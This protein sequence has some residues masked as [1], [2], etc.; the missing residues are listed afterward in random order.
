MTG[1]MHGKAVRC[2]LCD[3]GAVAEASHDEQVICPRC[4][5]RLVDR[6][7]CRNDRLNINEWLAVRGL[8]ALCL[9]WQSAPD[10]PANVLLGACDRCV[11][12]QPCNV[13]AAAPGENI[14]VGWCRFYGCCCDGNQVV[15]PDGA[16]DGLCFRCDAYRRRDLGPAPRFRFVTAETL[17]TRR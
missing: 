12:R 2:A 10:D 11:G 14:I 17:A 16:G 6:W 3:L 5:E 4:T 7:G 9:F 8:A 15:E 1:G 13:P